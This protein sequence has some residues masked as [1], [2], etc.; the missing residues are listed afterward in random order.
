MVFRCNFTYLQAKHVNRQH[1]VSYMLSLSNNCSTQ[2]ANA[3]P[4]H[5]HLV[6]IRV[7][8][9]TGSMNICW[10]WASSRSLHPKKTQLGLI[11]NLSLTE[12]LIV[13][14]ISEISSS[15]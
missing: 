5:S 10:A 11:A 14:E 6:E 1:L 8:A 9:P 2:L 3:F 7:I 4:G 15:D 12:R 13:E